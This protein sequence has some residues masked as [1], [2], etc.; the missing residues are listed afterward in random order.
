MKKKHKEGKEGEQ[1]RKTKKRNMK[2]KMKERKKKKKTT[3]KNNRELFVLI[4]HTRARAGLK[5][6]AKGCPDTQKHTPTNV[7]NLFSLELTISNNCT[8][9]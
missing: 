4:H 1:K 5:P 2:M 8:C 7:Y 3:K 9:C 6:S